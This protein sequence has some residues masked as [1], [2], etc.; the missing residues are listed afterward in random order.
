M[1]D[2]QTQPVQGEQAPES[3]SGLR[4]QLDAALA[5]N[6][7]LKQF[8][9][10]SAFKEAGF[11]LK[12]GEGKALARL[13]EGDADPDAIRAFAKSEFGWEPK[14]PE[15]SGGTDGGEQPTPERRELTAEEAGR[16]QAGGRV[17]S[18]MGEGRP[19][20]PPNVQT[21]I[22]EAEKAGEWDRAFSLKN[23]LMNEQRGITPA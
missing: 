19:L 14:S 11:D 1:A 20:D 17:D 15:G 7:E 23:Q 10:E 2:T 21:Q 8:K 22:A 9:R 4:A 5:E 6:R 3:P 12:G 16:L 18:V 13:Y